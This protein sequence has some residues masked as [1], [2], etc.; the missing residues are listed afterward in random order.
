MIQEYRNLFKINS[1]IT[2][3]VNRTN[4]KNVQTTSI[5]HL[6][7]FSI[8]QVHIETLEVLLNRQTL[9]KRQKNECPTVRMMQAKKVTDTS[10]YVPYVLDHW[11]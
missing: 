4:K 7:I 10:M 2:L 5:C 6:N 1:S 8:L 3:S 9:P 11:Y